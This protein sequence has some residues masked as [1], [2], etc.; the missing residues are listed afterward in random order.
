MNFKQRKL[1]K[2]LGKTNCYLEKS[3]LSGG[4]KVEKL[5][6]SFPVL[7][8][9]IAIKEKY[10]RRDL[11]KL[12]IQK[13]IMKTSRSYLMDIV[14]T[15]KEYY[16]QPGDKWTTE[17]VALFLLKVFNAYDFDKLKYIMEDKLV[18]EKQFAIDQIGISDKVNLFMNETL[19]T[20]KYHLLV[21]DLVTR[22]QLLKWKYRS[23]I[24]ESNRSKFDFKK[25]GLNKE[26]EE[27]VMKLF[28]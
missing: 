5:L 24:K 9:E 23:L 26:D 14:T 15:N 7:K 3:N 21:Y 12:E 2:L 16:R 1:E 18:I 11:E 17:M 8:D 20:D 10:Q 28:Y 27:I 13:A 19:K 22:E 25:E 4:E 6:N